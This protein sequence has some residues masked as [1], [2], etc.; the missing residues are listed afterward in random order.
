[1]FTGIIEQIGWVRSANRVASG[2][3]LSIEARFPDPPVLGD[4]IAVDGVCLT[5]TTLDEQGFSVDVS[6]ETL[7]RTTLAA[8]RVGQ[9]VNLERAVRLGQELG[10]HLVYGHVDTIIRVIAVELHGDNRVIRFELPRHFARFVAV[11]GS[12]AINGASLT[13]NA[14]SDAWFEVNLVPFTLAHTNLSDIKPGS[15]VNLEV[16]VIARYIDRML[17]MGTRPTMEDLVKDMV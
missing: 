15:R 8:F 7:K 11:K 5:V 14:V 6:G 3:K 10:G 2:L 13:T 12:V 17:T 16:D 9:K 1:M 4:S